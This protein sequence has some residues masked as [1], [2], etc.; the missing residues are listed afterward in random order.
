MSYFRSG[1]V[2]IPP[3][4]SKVMQSVNCRRSRSRSPA[5][6]RLNTPWTWAIHFKL[7]LQIVIANNGV[8]LGSILGYCARPSEL[9][10]MRRDWR[11]GLGWFATEGEGSKFIFSS[12]VFK[13]ELWATGEPVTRLSTT[14][15]CSFACVSPTLREARS[16]LRKLCK[17][18]NCISL[19]PPLDRNGA[20]RAGSER[21]GGEQRRRD[22]REGKWRAEEVRDG[23][24]QS[25]VGFMSVDS[26]GSTWSAPLSA[27]S[28]G[29]NVA[30]PI[31]T[32][33]AGS[34]TITGR[35]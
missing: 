25:T 33:P 17:P 15:C 14:Q 3:V 30:G 16:P 22:C 28:A 18:G 20:I 29:W 6:A 19:A 24:R 2:I 23:R 5:A 31:N 10:C 9:D 12:A 21:E 4:I 11:R 13:V 34:G 27:F 35:D 1:C 26:E 7:L 32:L 8:M